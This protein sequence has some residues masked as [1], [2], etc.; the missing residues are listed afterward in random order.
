MGDDWAVCTAVDG[1]NA[2]LSL[3]SESRL[4]VSAMVDLVS[5]FEYQF[6]FR[7]IVRLRV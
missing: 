1:V 3:D 4:S 5:I 2:L 7:M 6:S